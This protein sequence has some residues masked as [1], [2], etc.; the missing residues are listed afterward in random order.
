MTGADGG[1][2]LTLAMIMRTSTIPTELRIAFPAALWL[3]LFTTTAAAQIAANSCATLTANGSATVVAGRNCESPILLLTLAQENQAGS[4]FTSS[5]VAFDSKYE[6]RTSFQFQMSDPVYQAS[7]G[8]AFVIQAEGPNALGTVG[9]GLGYGGITPSV[10]IE[11]DTFQNAWDP[12]DNHVA[13]LLDGVFHD[14]DP[15]T[16]YGVTACQP[17][18]GFGCMNNGDV[19]TVWIDYDGRLMNV[20]IADNSTLRPANLISFP[21]DIASIL[22]G[23]LHSQA[24]RAARGRAPSGMSFPIGSSCSD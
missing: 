15:Q 21:I 10:A 2:D 18:G 7:D 3:P 8:M 24:S 17:T 16:P 11:F 12:N 19:W 1:G 6:F 13:F 5:P 20:A 23:S 9:G 22:G 4:V 14:I